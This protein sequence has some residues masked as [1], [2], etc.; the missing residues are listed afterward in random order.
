MSSNFILNAYCAFQ[1]ERNI[2]YLLELA[3]QDAFET[4]FGVRSAF[5]QQSS[6]EK[7]EEKI[8]FFLAGV[9][10]G[11]K[12]LHAR[13]IAYRDLKPENILILSDGYPVL[14]DFGV[15]IKTRP[16]KKLK[17]VRGTWLYLCP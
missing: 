5:R 1:D 16:D 2:F 12:E 10:L 9:V 4:F 15:S 7:I 13:K 14:T 8:R 11:L 17:E 3:N 6:L